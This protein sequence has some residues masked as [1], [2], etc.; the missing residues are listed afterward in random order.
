[1]AED[2]AVK[3]LIL[4]DDPNDAVLMTHELRRSGLNFRAKRVANREEFLQEIEHS[5]PDLILSDHGLPS[6]DGF[7]ALGLARAR[8]PEVPFLFVTGSLGEEL[9][10]ETLD[11]GATDY[12]L[13]H[14]LSKLG[15]AVQRALRESGERQRR[16]H[17]EAEREKLIA[18]LQEALAKV[19]TLTG[20]VPICSSCKKI[21]DDKGYWNLLE[22]YLQQHSN[23]TLTHG[24]CPECL[25]HSYADLTVRTGRSTRS[26]QRQADERPGEQAAATFLDP[27]LD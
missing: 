21:R 24:I 10:I 23:A 12:V 8:C 17:A 26:V 1:M 6:F 2:N 7:S 19:K 4:E 5:T 11:R 18:E 3:V 13:K 20:L 16:K 14:R 15:P 25:R 27:H 9:I 22:V